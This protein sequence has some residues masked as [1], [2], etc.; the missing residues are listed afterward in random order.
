MSMYAVA[1]VTGHT[2]SWVARFLLDRGE[3]V[4][5][6]VRSRDQIYKWRDRGAEVVVADLNDSIALTKA[7][8]GVRGAYLLSP[9][10]V[11][12]ADPRKKWARQNQSLVVAVQNAN[13]K[14]TVV[15]S[16][17][18][19]HRGDPKDLVFALSDLERQFNCT[20]LPVTALR[21][22]FFYENWIPA[23]GFVN[24]KNQLPTFLKPDRSIPMVSVKD[25]AQTA[26]DLLLNP[27]DSFRTVELSGPR[28]YSPNDALGIL[29]QTLG[30]KLELHVYSEKE[31]K[32]LWL[33][34]GVHE[35]MIDL[36]VA[37]YGGFDKKKIV[38]SEK[39]V[40][41]RKGTVALEE[42]L[43]RWAA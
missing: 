40:E 12:D 20:Q 31:W 32:Q 15:L 33:D 8:E 9:Q 2:G 25:V 4:R 30:E 43:S 10:S 42:V 17:M 7:L 18:G 41:A 22:A 29:E 23:M 39:N 27:V 21:A 14:N 26:V 6:I 34:E 5:A 35:E 24:D 36:L 16:S 19:A 3:K 13:L 38:F 11:Y 1:G 37:T 28:D